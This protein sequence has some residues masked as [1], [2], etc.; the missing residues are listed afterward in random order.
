MI[1]ANKKKKKSNPRRG[2]HFRKVLYEHLSRAR[3]K[4]T[5]FFRSECRG[6]A[7]AAA[8]IVLKRL[9]SSVLPV[10]LPLTFTL[11]AAYFSLALAVS[12]RS[13]RSLK[14]RVRCRAPVRVI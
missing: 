10:R 7:A 2:W 1:L 11:N 13:A 3:F 5:K 12:Q 8:V 6:L 14:Y 9:R 4:S